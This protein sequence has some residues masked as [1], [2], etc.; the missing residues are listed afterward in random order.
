VCVQIVVFSSVTPCSLVGQYQRFGV[1]DAFIFGNDP[2]GRRLLL[3]QHS[4][5]CCQHTHLNIPYS[6]ISQLR[7][8]SSPAGEKRNEGSLYDQMAAP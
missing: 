6:V 1:D 5:H 3:L 2:E 4:G 8:T 7:H